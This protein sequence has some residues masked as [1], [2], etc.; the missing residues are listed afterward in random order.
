[1]GPPSQAAARLKRTSLDFRRP[2]LTD[3]EPTPA[4]LA[5]HIDFMFGLPAL[6]FM[7]VHGSYCFLHFSGAV[8]GR[9]MA[10]DSLSNTDI[11]GGLLEP[12]TNPHIYCTLNSTPLSQHIHLTTTTAPRLNSLH[13]YGPHSTNFQHPNLPSAFLTIPVVPFTNTC[14]LRGKCFSCASLSRCLRCDL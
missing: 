12:S 4:C 1:M 8:G 6:I 14:N 11:H 10:S 2:L 5:R 7:Q 3:I 13:T 9:K